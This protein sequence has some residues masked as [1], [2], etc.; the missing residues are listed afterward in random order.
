MNV[1]L[2]TSP[3]PAS[4]GFST[5]EKRPPLGVGLLISALEQR[6]HTVEFDDQ[7]LKPWPIFDDPRYLQKNNIEFVGIYSNTICL[8]GTLSLLR[9]LQYLREH[10]LWNGKIAVGGPHA[11]FGAQQLPE[12]VDHICIGEGDITFPEMVEGTERGRIVV[13]KKVAD[14]DTLPRPAWHHF[15]YKGY[16]WSSGWDSGYPMYTFNTSRGCPFPCTFCSVK[17]VWGKTY[18]YM[19]A[20]R[21]ID[22]VLLMQQ[23]YGMKAA[24][25]REDHFTLNTNRIV[26]FCESLL[27]RNITFPWICESRADSIEKPGLIALMARA[28]CKALYIGVESGSQRM[29]DLFKKHEKVEQFEYVIKEARKVGIRTYASMLYGV[30]GETPEDIELSEQFLQRTTPDFIGRNIFAGLPG[31]ELYNELRDSGAYDYEDENGLLYPVGYEARAKCAYGETPYYAVVSRALGTATPAKSNQVMRAA[32]TPEISIIMPAY[33]ASAFGAEAIESML[34]QTFRDFELLIIDDASTD[35][36][37]EMLLARRDPRVYLHRNEANLGVTATLNK[38]L[39]MAR[40]KYI[41]RMDADDISHP[42]RLHAQ[43]SHMKNNP[44]VWVCGSFFSFL[45]AD[46]QTN[47]VQVPVKNDAIR[48]GLLFGNN[49]AHP[50]VMLHGDKFREH[51]LLYDKTVKLAQDYALWLHIACDFPEAKFS[52]LPLVLGQYRHHPSSISMSK[53]EEQFNSMLTS[54]MYALKRLGFSA[55]DSLI[56]A[57]GHLVMNLPVETQAQMVRVFEWAISL[58]KANESKGL[59]CKAAL[60]GIL[61]DKLIDISERNQQFASVSS[62][63]LKIMFM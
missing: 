9:K 43:L 60:R 15:I 41:A 32:K 16:D 13:G 29:L 14:M 35:D 19:S 11:S 33:N 48:A 52:N 58:L 28:G 63:F 39:G 53:K 50:F 2:L 40:G 25:F 38:L 7:Y 21:I 47:V 57:H 34:A 17:G 12:Y 10:K 55:N 22:D 8:Q 61:Q 45:H 36:T 59:F 6:G 56:A 27:Q 5:M 23:Y 46:G 1:L 42:E 18:R 37:N 62:K 31:S 49:L 26:T 4:G 20:E 24:Y 3:A 51:G 30:P 44:D 54:Q